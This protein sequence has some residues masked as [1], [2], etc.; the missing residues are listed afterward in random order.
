MDNTSIITSLIVELAVVDLSLVESLLNCKG[1]I[2][3]FTKLRSKYCTVKLTHPTALFKL[4]W[5]YSG[6]SALV[7]QR[8]SIAKEIW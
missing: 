5:L 4:N 1:V 2:K 8:S 7:R 3:S 6:A